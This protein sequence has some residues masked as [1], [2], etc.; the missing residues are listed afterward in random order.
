VQLLTKVR[1]DITML[2]GHEHWA[3]KRVEEE[4]RCACLKCLRV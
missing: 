1:D 4:L 3:S 2:L